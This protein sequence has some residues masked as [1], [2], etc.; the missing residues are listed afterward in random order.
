M[1]R[2]GPKLCR[3]SSLVLPARGLLRIWLLSRQRTGLSIPNADMR[4][5]VQERLGLSWDV[6]AEWDGL[7]CCCKGAPWAV[8]AHLEV[9]GL[10]AAKFRVHDPAC[11]ILREC[12][13]STG[14]AIAPKEPR[15]LPGA[16]RGGGDL[17]M[18]GGGGE[19]DTVV[20]VTFPSVA[21][22]GG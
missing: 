15:G 10:E 9:C 12:G 8:G 11:A 17:L 14:L 19:L 18:R 20:D 13:R 6:D 2:W 22:S 7:K 21:C 1:G 4:M 3:P 5:I 16:G